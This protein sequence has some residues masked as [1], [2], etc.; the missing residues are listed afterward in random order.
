MAIAALAITRVESIAAA[1]MRAEKQSVLD[2]TLRF[3]FNAAGIRA[4]VAFGF[5]DRALTRSRARP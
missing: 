2:L 1:L 3:A 4:Q 5:E